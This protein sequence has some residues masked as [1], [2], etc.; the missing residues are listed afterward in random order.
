MD[1]PIFTTQTIQESIQKRMHTTS[2][3]QMREENN[4]T[5]F[6]KEKKQKSIVRQSYNDPL[7]DDQNYLQTIRY[8]EALQ[9]CDK[10]ASRKIDIAIID[11]AFDVHHED[12]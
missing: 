10:E 5:N 6:L 3:T 12:F 7:V 11:S 2:S 8:P 1:Q 9:I 4:F